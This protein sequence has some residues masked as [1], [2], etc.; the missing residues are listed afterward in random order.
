MREDLDELEQLRV[1][2]LTGL[3]KEEID[4][5]WAGDWNARPALDDDMELTEE[6]IAKDMAAWDFEEAQAVAMAENEDEIA[7]DKIRLSIRGSADNPIVHV[8]PPTEG[9]QNPSVEDAK[10]LRR[11]KSL[12]FNKG[13]AY[14]A[15]EFAKSLG[16]S[17][18]VVRPSILEMNWKEEKE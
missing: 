12:R 6:E 3:T 5:C 15:Q 2:D 17:G 9:D 10:P 1:E 8:I 16:K 14:H 4:E 13:G 7:A 11:Q 18:T